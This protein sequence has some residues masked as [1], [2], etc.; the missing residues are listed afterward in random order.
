MKKTSVK[1][2]I[3]VIEGGDG[4]GKGTQLKLLSD[5]LKNKGHV[6][7]EYD[8]PQY[9]GSTFGKLCGEALKGAHGD[10]R[11]MSPYLASLPY[12]LDRLSAREKMVNDLKRG[13]V[14]CNR[15][16]PS[17]VAYQSSKLKGV[18]KEEF[19]TFL[20]RAEYEEFGLPKPTKV[21][22]LYVPPKNSHAL[23]AKKEAR[24]YLGNK[25]NARDQHEKDLS[26]QRAVSKTYLD[27]AAKDVSG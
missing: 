18:K 3:F 27:L 21:I 5:V 15:Y 22:Y 4:S 9:E 16:T 2:K 13:I 24:T 8:F 11:N 12:T 20:E 6:I 26:F 14:L 23:V 19:I 1:N 7:A 10:F 17:N 25:K